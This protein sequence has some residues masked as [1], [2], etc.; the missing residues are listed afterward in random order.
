MAPRAAAVESHHTNSPDPTQPIRVLDNHAPYEGGLSGRRPR[1]H[2]HAINKWNDL[3]WARPLRRL[4][5][6]YV[7]SVRLF[8]E[9]TTHHLSHIAA[10][11]YRQKSAP[12]VAMK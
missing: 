8:P 5:P 1:A 11:V 2:R 10:P 6:P 3:R 12:D 4:S 9:T 7:L